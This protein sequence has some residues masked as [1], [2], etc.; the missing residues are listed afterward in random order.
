MINLIRFVWY[1][2]VVALIIY[3][4]RQQPKLQGINNSNKREKGF[5]ISSSKE[6]S[7]VL[8]TWMLILIYISLT[9]SLTKFGEN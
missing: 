9:V 1:F 2:S 7:L 3:I 4:L 8:Q 5:S 6:R